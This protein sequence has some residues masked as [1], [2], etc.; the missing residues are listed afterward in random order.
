MSGAGRLVLAAT[1]LGNPQD[2]SVRLIEAMSHADVIAAEDT[3][4]FH[5]LARD[6]GVNPR[7]R[8]ISLHDSVEASRAESL[9]AAVRGGDTV[10]VVSDAGMPAIS[11]PGYRLVRACLD[12]GLEVGVL[13][14]P[15]AVLAALVVSGLPVDRF[16]FEG[17]LP[18]RSGERRRRIAALADEPRTMVFFEAPHRIGDALAD[19]VEAFGSDRPA[20]LCR[21]LT[22]TYEEVR[23]GSLSELVDGLG[24]P[25]G[26][27]TLVVAG[28][29]AVGPRG[30]A[31]VWGTAVAARVE[32]GSDAKSAIAAVAT[33]YAAP[34]REV[35]DA[36]VAVKAPR[37]R[38]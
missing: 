14:G 11:D 30:D 24:E 17:F 13:P 16:C 3:R 34:R 7:G 37:E 23:R 12:E 22:K 36:Y 5:R 18:R 10:L 28:A 33:E 20:A 25:R 29:T 19:L 1:P 6:L 26:E 15:S 2:A 8:I 31:G 4:R 32:Q 38:K 27:I 21:E 9:V 35:Y